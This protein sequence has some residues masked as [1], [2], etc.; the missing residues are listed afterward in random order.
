MFWKV[1]QWQCLIP[2][3][4]EVEVKEMKGDYS[5]GQLSE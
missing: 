2:K 5:S 3:R 1:G 4:E